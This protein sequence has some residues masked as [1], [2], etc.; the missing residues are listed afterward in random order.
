M[1]WVMNASSNSLTSTSYKY[2]EFC[3]A[4]AMRD[5]WKRLDFLGFRGETLMRGEGNQPNFLDMHRVIF[6]LADF[7]INIEERGT[8]SALYFSARA[9]GLP[10]IP[11]FRYGLAKDLFPVTLFGE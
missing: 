1:L 7:T 6:F 5:I 11:M 10:D 4:K 8:K 2:K 3:V 9:M